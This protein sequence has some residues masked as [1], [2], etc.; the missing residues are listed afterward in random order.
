MEMVLL[1][2]LQTMYA[3]LARD[4]A[5]HM[6]LCGIF[7]DDIGL[8]VF[9]QRF[10]FTLRIWKIIIPEMIAKERERGR[11]KKNRI[12]SVLNYTAD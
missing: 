8:L 4:A 9:C 10:F 2:G 1:I 7:S 11:E 12:A 3:P 5:S 6:H